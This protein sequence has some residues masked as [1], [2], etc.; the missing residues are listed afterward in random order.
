M[1]NNIKMVIVLIVL[2]KDDDDEN[3]NVDDADN[4]DHDECI[5]ENHISIEWFS[6]TWYTNIS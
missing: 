1:I 4:H 5:K 2:I 3:S 6:A